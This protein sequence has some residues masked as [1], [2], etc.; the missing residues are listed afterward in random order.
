MVGMAELV[1][2]CLHAVDDPSKFSMT[3]D[4]SPR[5]GMQNA[6]PTLPVRGSASIQFSRKARERN[7]PRRGE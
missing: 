7:A 5:I 3:R 2:Q 1:G 4:S 6:P